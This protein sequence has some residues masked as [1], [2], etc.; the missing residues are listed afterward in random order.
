MVSD[1]HGARVQ[2][3][4]EDALQKGAH[5]TCGGQFDA[6]DRYVA[7]TLLTELP[8]D[9]ALMEEEIFGPILPILTFNSLPEVVAA[10]SRKPNPLALYLFTQSEENKFLS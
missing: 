10:V 8:P 9:A 5:L 1:S 3:L 2:R 6:A 4:C 7:P